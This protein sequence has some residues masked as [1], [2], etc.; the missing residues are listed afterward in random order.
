MPCKKA[1]CRFPAAAVEKAIE[2]NG[3]SVE[4]NLKSF[5]WGRR[6][7]VDLARVQ[8]IATP[9]EIIPISQHLSRNLDELVANRVEFLSAY[10]DAAYAARYRELVEKVRRI[11]TEK[12]SG[13]KLSE[14]VARYYA[15]L[16]AYK[17]EYEVARLHADP[18]FMQ[19]IE[20]MFEGDYKVVFHLAPPM[21]NKPDPATGEA[22]K[23]TFGPW[24]M[25]GFRLLAKLKG[26]RGTAFDIFGRTEERKT[27]RALIVE[28]AATVEE[29][30]GKLTPANH[31]LAVEI[32]SVPEMIRGYGHV[33]IRHLKQAQKQR[34]E[35]LAKF[36]APVERTAKAA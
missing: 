19:K 5:V 27:E 7:A 14:A 17:D 28:Y 29:L 1:G 35:L 4:F 22:K 16:L 21:L 13:T 6:A 18:A 26:L 12:A 8:K 11:E 33:K 30:L 23:S 10:Q 9:A 24:M 15:K 34:A 20:G 25:R 31:A 32:A 3:V 36:N 2:L